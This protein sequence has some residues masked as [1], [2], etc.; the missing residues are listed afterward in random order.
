MKYTTEIV[1]QLVQL[2]WNCM[3]EFCRFVDVRN[4]RKFLFHFFPRSYPPFSKMNYINYWKFFIATS[5]PKTV[6]QRFVKLCSYEG[7]TVKMCIISGPIFWGSCNPFELRNL[8]KINYTEKDFKCN[9]SETTQQNFMK[10]CIYMH[11]WRKF[12]FFIFLAVTGMP[13]LNLKILQKIKWNFVVMFILRT[14]CV[15]VHIYR[16]FSFCFFFWENK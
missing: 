1:C 3:T 4:S 14:Y 12:W 16:K 7:H 5:S 10:L 9:S 11:I 8:A 13:L 2:L 6:L 15:H